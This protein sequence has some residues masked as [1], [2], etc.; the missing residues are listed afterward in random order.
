ML[1]YICY[2]IRDNCIYID[3]TMDFSRLFSAFEFFISNLFNLLAYNHSFLC[4]VVAIVFSYRLLLREI[5]KQP[6]FNILLMKR[7]EKPFLALKQF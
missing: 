6:S 1:K 7:P 4:F 3:F 5:Q 2:L